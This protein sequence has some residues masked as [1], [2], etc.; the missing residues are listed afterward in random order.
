[1]LEPLISVVTPCNNQARFLPEAVASLQAQLYP[2]WEC[3]IVDDGSSDD[4]VQVVKALAAAD[5]RIRLI[6]QEN[7][8]LPAARNRGLDESR[9]MIVHFLDADDYILPEM[10]QKMV[11]VFQSW[12]DVTVVY[13]GYQFVNAERMLLKSFPTIPK[14]ADVFHRLLERNLWP[15][16]ALMVRKAVIDSVG[17]FGENLRA[18]EDWDLWLRIAASGG[19]FVPV[20]GE[21]ACYRRYAGTMSD[22]GWRMLQAGFTII[23]KNRR[24]HKRCQ[25]CKVA[26]KRGRF[27]LARQCWNGLCSDLDQTVGEKCSRYVRFLLQ[28]ASR[29]PRVACYMLLS[30]LLRNRLFGP[31]LAR[32]KSLVFIS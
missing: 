11:D 23:E 24:W 7:R 31:A 3:I 27:H 12:S 14:P 20:S 18:C 4:T 22:N 21:F 32:I 16:H 26:A 13:S 5:T 25:A 15:C 1:M 17:G 28:V 9:G 29:E 19:T 2:H 30:M 6:S 8:G 10:Y